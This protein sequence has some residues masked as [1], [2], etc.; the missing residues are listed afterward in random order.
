M[1]TP[2]KTI[3][4]SLL[5]TLLI[6]GWP[7]SASHAADSS[8]SGV[9][10]TNKQRISFSTV[11]YNTTTMCFWGDIQGHVSA[12]DATCV[13]Y[14]PTFTTNLTAGDGEKIIFASYKDA[15]GTVLQTLSTKVILDA[16]PP[17][18]PLF[19][20]PASTPDRNISL[21]LTAPSDGTAV[22]ISGDIVNTGPVFYWAAIQSSYPLILTST[23]GIKTI[24]VQ[25]KDAAGNTSI[26]SS[27]ISKYQPSAAEVELPVIK[28]PVKN[29]PANKN[30]NVNRT[31]APPVVVANINLNA[32]NENVN[33]SLLD[34][35][36]DEDGD[37]LANGKEEEIGTDPFDN[38]TDHD[39]LDDP[40]EV[41]E[42]HT[43]PLFQDSDSDACFDGTEVRQKTDPLDTRSSD[44]Q[45][46]ALNSN[47]N[48][49][50]SGSLDTD[51][52]GLSDSRERNL[53]TDPGNADTDADGTSD[54]LEVL[55]FGT[56]PFS[57]TPPE[58]FRR[59]R[60]VNWADNAVMTG[61]DWLVQGSCAAP[62]HI[63]ISFTD[64]ANKSTL[65]GQIRCQSN[66]IFLLKTSLTLPDGRYLL[67][68]L[69]HDDQGL[70]LENARSIAIVID[71]TAGLLP[72]QPEKIDDTNVPAMTEQ[73]PMIEANITIV[74]QRPVV[75]GR[76]GY[77]STVNASFESIITTS[78]IVADS[79]IGDFA[80]TTPNPLG[81]GSHHVTLYAI[82]KN[83]QRSSAVQIPF[84]IVEKTEAQV[85]ADTNLHGAAPKNAESLPWTLIL[86]GIVGM[87]V[88][89][90]LWFLFHQTPAKTFAL[91]NP[92][93]PEDGGASPTPPSQ[94]DE[95]MEQKMLRLIPDENNEVEPPHNTD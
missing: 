82:G 64:K 37:G 81:L 28:P 27:H 52:D 51:S 94:A 26:V 55:Q 11:A 35:L 48:N 54:G 7:M 5:I 73:D 43:N 70:F 60:I 25:V 75:Y 79:S 6:S 62:S 91:P 36:G 77:S 88:A 74:N 40:A 84:T 32:Q 42:W 41:N 20:V 18:P 45:D 15:S 59:L 80:I 31:A 50:L 90:N 21:S 30:K 93:S 71:K 67:S 66:N 49:T 4:L 23:E 17:N 12:G 9:R 13:P 33:S 61:S 44:C 14:Q 58:S 89:W 39:F 10:L 24:S 16:T 29:T 46:P 95:E 57:L 1:Q 87:S 38:D 92:A 72:P 8:F 2:I 63:K 53:G 85:L 68:A 78:S 56:N 22:Y 65:L 34:P 86:L 76:T 19:S 83:G 69:S 3:S 47:Q